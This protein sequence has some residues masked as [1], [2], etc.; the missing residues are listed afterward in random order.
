M[1]TT[2]NSK[3]C[4]KCSV[5][6]SKFNIDEEGAWMNWGMVL[7]KVKFYNEVKIESVSKRKK[8]FVN[9]FSFS[10]TNK[11]VTFTFTEIKLCWGE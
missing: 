9:N 2:S 3:H 5:V 4:P 8:F 10:E 11:W 1:N 7:E 6:L